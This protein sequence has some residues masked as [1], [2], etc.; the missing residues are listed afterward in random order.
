MCVCASLSL[1]RFIWSEIVS[2]E[3]VQSKIKDNTQ[4]AHV[5]CSVF[6]CSSDSIDIRPW[7]QHTTVWR[8]SWKPPTHIHLPCL[9]LPCLLGRSLG[10][11]LVRSVVNYRRLLDFTSIAY[12]FSA[13]FLRNISTVIDGRLH[14]TPLL[15]VCT[16]ARFLCRTYDLPNLV[17]YWPYPCYPFTSLFHF[18]FILHTYA[19]VCCRCFAAAT[20]VI[21]FSA[22]MLCA[23]FD[24]KWAYGLHCLDNVQIS[25]CSALFITI[26]FGLFCFLLSAILPFG[27]QQK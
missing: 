10:R 6:L 19:A 21:G 13:F 5:L 22:T 1:S 9:A 3:L 20:L 12:E 11:S 25:T 26:Y 8:Q 7:V 23:K 17:Q 15:S 27:S 4:A 2:V 14:L 24:S 16:R 18:K